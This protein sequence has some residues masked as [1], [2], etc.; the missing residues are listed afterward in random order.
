MIWSPF[1]AGITPAACAQSGSGIGAFVCQVLASD[2]QHRVSTDGHIA[3][4]CLTARCDGLGA[5]PVYLKLVSIRVDPAAGGGGADV[6]SASAR[7]RDLTGHHE[8]C[9]GGA[10][11]TNRDGP[12]IFP[13][14]EAVACHPG[15]PDAVRSSS[16]ALERRLGGWPNVPPVGAV[17][18]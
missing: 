1:D 17:S 12:R 2:E 14:N 18:P 15:Q 4:G 6:N 8:V 3:D 7:R 5:T 10:A 16:Q 13:F 11:G 9:G